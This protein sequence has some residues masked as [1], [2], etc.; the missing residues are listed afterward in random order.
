M[1]ALGLAHI[2]P[3]VKDGQ[4][5]TVFKLFDSPG[6]SVMLNQLF[7]ALNS[8]FQPGLLDA[9]FRGYFAYAIRDYQK[10]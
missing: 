1:R 10:A 7:F 4:N 8:L 9:Q 2:K 3:R 6:M 5:S